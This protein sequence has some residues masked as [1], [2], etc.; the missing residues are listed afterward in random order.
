MWVVAWIFILY[1]G[2][3]NFSSLVSHMD[4]STWPSPVILFPDLLASSC[5]C[6]DQYSSNNLHGTLSNSLELSLV[7]FPLLLS[8]CQI[9]DLFAFPKFRYCLYFRRN[10]RFHLGF[11]SLYSVL[12]SLSKLSLRVILG[13]SHVSSFRDH[14]P[15]LSVV[16]CLK[17]I[18]SYFELTQ[19]KYHR[20]GAL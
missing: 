18:V 5:S 2:N 16:Q 1:G 19:A 6:F 7:L 9:L 8:A 12:E 3:I 11:F 15:T 14:C 17:T 10:R 20:L 4:L 13:S